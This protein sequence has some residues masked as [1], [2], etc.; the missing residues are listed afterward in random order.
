MDSNVISEKVIGPILFHVTYNLGLLLCI[1]VFNQIYKST[2]R[3]QNIKIKKVFQE[4]EY[5]IKLNQLRDKCL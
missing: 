5:K 2:G 3:A 4:G 1:C